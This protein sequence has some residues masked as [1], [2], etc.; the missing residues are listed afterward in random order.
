MCNSVDNREKSQHRDTNWA[1]KVNKKR[2]ERDQQNTGNIKWRICARLQVESVIGFSVRSNNKIFA[3]NFLQNE[4]DKDELK[5][6]RYG[7]MHSK[8]YP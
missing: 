1:L 3:G 5:A 4:E 7:I 8:K 2:F 6:Y